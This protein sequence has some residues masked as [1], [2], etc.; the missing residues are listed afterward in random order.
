[1]FDSLAALRVLLLPE[2]YARSL[3]LAHLQQLATLSLFRLRVRYA[4]TQPDRARA[5]GLAAGENPA[6]RV[7][8]GCSRSRLRRARAR[9]GPEAESCQFAV[10]CV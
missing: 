6:A 3:S 2:C 10:V 5:I 4:R 1:M 8:V 7:S 9:A